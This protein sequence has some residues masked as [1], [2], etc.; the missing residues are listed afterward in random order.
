VI[1]ICSHGYTG[2]IRW[3][4]LGSV[5]AKVARF[6]RI[7]V[8]ILREGGPLPQERHPGEQPL[9]VLVPLDGS[10][11]MLVFVTQPRLR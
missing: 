3:W 8:L 4:M 10:D 9:R 1:V 5:A 6:A 2:V 7:P 11:Y